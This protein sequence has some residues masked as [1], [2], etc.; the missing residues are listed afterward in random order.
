MQVLLPLVVM[1]IGI[2]FSSAA[3]YVA[4]NNIIKGSR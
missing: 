4:V 1:C 3:M 2:G